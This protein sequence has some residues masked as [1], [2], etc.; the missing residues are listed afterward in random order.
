MT[1]AARYDHNLYQAIAHRAWGVAHRLADEYEEAEARLNQALGIFQELETRWQIGRTL[2]ELAELALVR[3][4]TAQAYDYFSRALV[5]F[6]AIGAEPDA[7]RIRAA[8]ESLD[9]FS[10]RFMV[11][12]LTEDG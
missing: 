10:G 4:E 1:A 12:K 6:E 3:R 7:A 8:L 9:Y 11:N 2:N 5:A